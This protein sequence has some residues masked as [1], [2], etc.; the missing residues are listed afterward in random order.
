MEDYGYN[1]IHNWPQFVTTLIPRKNFSI[2]LKP[3]SFK[4]VNFL[5]NLYSKPRQEYRKPKSKIGDK[6]HFS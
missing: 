5:S 2:N 6:V 4:N 3:N 1:Y